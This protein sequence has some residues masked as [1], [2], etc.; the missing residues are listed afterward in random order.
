MEHRYQV[1]DRVKLAFGFFDQDASGTYQIA[2]LLPTR[3]D[4]DPQYR[5]LGGDDRLRVIGQAQ[6]EEPGKPGY[7]VRPRSGH[8]PI[9]EGLNAVRGKGR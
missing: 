7:P 6:I 3:P 1:G 2:D 8:N 9:T 5:I 4:G